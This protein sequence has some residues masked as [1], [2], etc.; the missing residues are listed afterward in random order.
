MS[1]IDW[2]DWWIANPLD[3]GL[4]LLLPDA[5][6][7]KYA[8]WTSTPSA[9]A[10]V[11]AQAINSASVILTWDKPADTGNGLVR[12][13]VYR[14]GQE[15]GKPKT[16]PFID[17]GLSASATYQY[18]VSALCVGA[19]ESPKS[20][21]TAVTTPADAAPPA[22]ALASGAGDGKTVWIIF[23]EPVEQSSAQT[24][25]NYTIDNG[26]SIASAAL[27]PDQKTVTVTTSALTK[28]VTYSLTVNN[29]RDRAASPN[30]I[31][32]NTRASFTYVEGITRIRLYP[33]PNYSVP[34]GTRLIG[35]G[36]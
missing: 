4:N 17:T 33:R 25:G 34:I 13:L 18:E 20:V 16:G 29:I 7:K 12:Y 22:I 36:L 26:I 3:H 2:H 27:G 30:T 23:S 14:N 19:I 6:A 35:G 8:W 11:A 31:A 1:W 9:P 21:K 5:A 28:G 24:A 15:I 32:Q 10:N